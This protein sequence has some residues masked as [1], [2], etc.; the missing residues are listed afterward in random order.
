MLRKIVKLFPLFL[1]AGIIITACDKK[2]EV[3]PDY[4]VVAYLWHEYPVNAPIEA[5]CFTHLNYAF[6]NVNDS[7]NGVDILSP[8]CFKRVVAL[9]DTFPHLKVLLSMGGG[10]DSKFSRMAADSLKRLAFAVDINRI[11]T[12]YDIDGVDF[13]WEIPGNKFG[14][15]EDTINYV[16]MIRDVRAAIGSDKLISI[17]GG[18]ELGGVDGKAVLP[19]VDYFNAMTYDLSWA[20][21]HHTGIHRSPLVGWRC[22]DETIAD[23]HA[24]GVPD[25][26]IVMGLAFYGR[27]DFE[28]FPGWYNYGHI[29]DH[30]DDLTFEWDSIAQVPYLMNAD[31]ALVLS[32]DN[33]ESLKIKCDYIK[34]NGY[35]GA[36]YWRYACDDSVGT[37]RHTVAQ[38]LLG[39]QIEYEK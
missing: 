32:F 21:Q 11:I 14:V 8:D 12:E 19:Y 5:T 2:T 27:G 23:Y 35:K 7:L 38:E 30:Y 25:S 31:S 26:M 33:P 16:K 9:K 22:I 3:K 18:G 10:N 36:M 29:A 15:P 17:A 1:L 37:L 6:G 34:E 24:K 28:R 4:M 20:G 39:G 13:D